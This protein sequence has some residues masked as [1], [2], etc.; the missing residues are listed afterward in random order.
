MEE[1]YEL[2]FYERDEDINAG[3]DDDLFEDFC[4]ETYGD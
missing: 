3:A 1:D 2:S 4:K